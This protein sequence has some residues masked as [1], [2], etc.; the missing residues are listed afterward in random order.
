MIESGGVIGQFRY[1]PY[2]ADLAVPLKLQLMENDHLYDCYD[3]DLP[4]GNTLRLGIEITR[5]GDIAAYHLYPEHP[6]DNY[7]YKSSITPIRVSADDILHLYEPK[8]PGQLRGMPWL[9][10]V[11]TTLHN[12]DEYED[13]ERIRKKIAAMYAGFITSPEGDPASSGLPGL[14]TEYDDDDDLVGLEPGLMQALRPGEKIEW[15]K[16]ADV[17]DTF[18]PWMKFGYRQV[19]KSIRVTYEQLS[20]DLKDVNYSSIRAGLVEIYRQ[21][22]ALIGQIIVHKLCRPYTT[23]WL[24]IAVLS[25]RIFIP[26]YLKNR[27]Q[28]INNIWDPDGWDW[29]DPL[30]DIKAEIM[31]IRAGLKSRP[32]SVG[33]RGNNSAEIDASTAEANRRADDSGIV[34]DSDPRKT[35]QS[36]SKQQDKQSP[37]QG[38]YNGQ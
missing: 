37:Q 15:S 26:R 33:E 27:R 19:A 32:Q 20:G 6:G 22:R 14:E 31:A 34:Y 9:A 38:A 16:P 25:N 2:S 36:G 28:I 17:G 30:K 35:T 1:Y 24:D 5:D 3:Q 29:V 4:N 11:I 13:A 7:L 21:A 18:E 12:I 23:R 10:Q 8:R